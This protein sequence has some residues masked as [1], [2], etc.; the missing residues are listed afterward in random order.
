MLDKSIFIVMKKM[1]KEKV[2][3]FLNENKKTKSTREVAGVLIKCSKTNRFLLLERNDG[4][5]NERWSMITGGVDKGETIIEGLKR[6]V[7]EEIGINPELIKYKFIKVIPMPKKNKTLHYYQGL[8]ST[9]FKPILNKEH[10]DWGW[11][12]VDELPSPLY[13]NTQEKID[14]YE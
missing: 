1:I 11:F 7:N 14:D 10:H 13:P 12:S 5:K 9:E 6:E 3:A 4:K 8:T 2:K